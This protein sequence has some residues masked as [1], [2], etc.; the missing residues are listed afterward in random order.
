MYHCLK[1][2]WQDGTACIWKALHSLMW[3]LFEVSLIVSFY[4]CS[5]LFL[6]LKTYH[7]QSD[8]I[9][10]SSVDM[11]GCVGNRLTDTMRPSPMT[12]C[13]TPLIRHIVLQHGR[14]PW[15]AYK[16]ITWWV[17]HGVQAFTWVSMALILLSYCFCMSAA[18]SNLAPQSTLPGSSE[19]LG[20]A[21]L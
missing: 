2:C 3:P 6:E 14:R 7:F 18:G 15:L 16:S 20:D 10:S 13:I 5:M 19:L 12:A 21:A 9:S 11:L 8:E 4:I 1:L 17:L